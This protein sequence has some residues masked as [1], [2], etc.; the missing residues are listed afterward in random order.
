MLPK[1]VSRDG[2]RKVESWVDF[3]GVDMVGWV[4]GEMSR[5]V[6]VCVRVRTC[7][8]ILIFSD[9]VIAV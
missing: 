5:R 6:Y 1:V 7:K 2:V 9:Y 4:D 8:R 3:R